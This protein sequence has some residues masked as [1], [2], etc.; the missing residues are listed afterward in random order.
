MDIRT[1]FSLFCIFIAALQVIFLVALFIG[2]FNLK[3]IDEANIAPWAT[4]IIV[5]GWI[6]MMIGAGIARRKKDKKKGTE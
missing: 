5:L 6:S 2:V 1:K 3:I 4:T